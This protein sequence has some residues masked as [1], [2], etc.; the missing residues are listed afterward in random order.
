MEKAKILLSPERAGMNLSAVMGDESGIYFT[1]Q[2]DLAAI[3]ATLPA[4]LEPAFPLVSG[5]VVEI[6]KPAFCPR[7]REAMLGVYANYKGT[8]GMFPVAFLLSGPGAE[9][10]TLGGRERYGLPKK[11]CAN[12]DDISIVREEGRARATARRGDVTLLDVSIKFGSYND[13]MCANVYSGN[14]AGAKAG[15]TAF[16]AQ[17]IIGPGDSG[18][19][20]FKGVNLYAN[21]TEYTYRTWDAGEVTVRLQSSEDDAWGDFPVF[22]NLGGAW[23][24]N[25]IE[26]KALRQIETLDAS[27]MP[28]LLSTRYD[29]MSLR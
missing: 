3:A 23:S 19:V 4:P 6:K 20:E 25:D 9:M 13:Q 29:R 28:K 11:L 1:F 18:L 12:E 14:A 2:S 5:Y 27:A 17:P 16:Y 24:D 15:G 22:A 8:I 10:A 7:Y 26:M 21:E